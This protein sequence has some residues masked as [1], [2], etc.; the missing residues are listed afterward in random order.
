MSPAGTE[1]MPFVDAPFPCLIVPSTL[2]ASLSDDVRHINHQSVT[3]W[4]DVWAVCLHTGVR[5]RGGFATLACNRIE[6]DQRN[7]VSRTTFY[8]ATG[9][10]CPPSR[11]RT[12]GFTL[13]ELVM[14]LVIFGVVTAFALPGFQNMRAS[15]NLRATTTDLL[16]AAH[17]AR[18]S[19]VDQRG[20]VELRPRDGADWTS[21]W[22]VDYAGGDIDEENVGF[23]PAGDVTVQGGDPVVFRRNGTA[24]AE[25]EFI[26]CG[27]ND[28]RR[29][30]IS[31][32]GRVTS[33]EHNC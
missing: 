16:M 4:I 6:S 8:P 19:A 28:G 7:A 33:T 23:V 9:S 27:K 5:D 22:V 21:G 11:R 17:T 13:V 1:L 10:R 32:V 26:V 12:A 18:A 15:S 29:V 2:F 24:G 3:A 14:V 30:V 20:D 25:A 31:R